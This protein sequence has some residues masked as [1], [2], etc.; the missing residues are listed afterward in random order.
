M[1]TDL[2][3]VTV[4]PQVRA[5]RRLVAVLVV[6]ATIAALAW[7]GWSW[8]H[9]AAFHEYGGFGV[10]FDELRDGGT[11]FVGMSYVADGAEDEVTIHSARAVT[12]SGPSTATVELLVCTFDEDAGVGAL[13][14]VGED[15]IE[16]DCA[17]LV[18]A[19]GATLRLSGTPTQQLIVAFSLP[20]PGRLK[21]RG[22]EVD[23]SHGWRRGT[24]LVGG[25]IDAV[26]KKSHVPNRS[27]A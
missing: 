21:I 5:V 18:P 10:G 8:R 20:E 4:P 12:R 26:R 23:Y 9:P 17:S 27:R 13:G 22:V 3:V 15:E 1:S 14:A 16:R 2:E 6:L 25:D 24:Q 7:A 11:R 19:E